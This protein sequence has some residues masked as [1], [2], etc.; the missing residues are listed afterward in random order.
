MVIDMNVM[1]VYTLNCTIKME[2]KLQML[3]VSIHTVTTESGTLKTCSSTG[4]HT[5]KKCFSSYTV[6]TS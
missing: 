2:N 3:T 4:F 5:W 6:V 1:V